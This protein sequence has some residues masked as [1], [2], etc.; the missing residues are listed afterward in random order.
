MED[1]FKRIVEA[2]FGEYD[3]QTKKSKIEDY[4]NSIEWRMRENIDN[5][6]KRWSIDKKYVQDPNYIIREIVKDACY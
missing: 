3:E 1:Y 2:N 6:C 4:A 5:I